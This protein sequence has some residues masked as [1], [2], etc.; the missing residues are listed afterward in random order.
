METWKGWAIPEITGRKSVKEAH[1]VKV[2]FY[3]YAI[4]RA[5]GNLGNRELD[6][7][8]L[9]LR[10]VADGDLIAHDRTEVG[11]FLYDAARRTFTI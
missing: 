5:K 2:N 6:L 1:I 9:G 3:A 8:L 10:P 11:G 7:Q 4:P